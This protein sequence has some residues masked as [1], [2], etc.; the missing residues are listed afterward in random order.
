MNAFENTPVP[1]TDSHAPS[2]LDA[3]IRLQQLQLDTWL[4]WQQGWADAAAEIY[5]EWAC[6]FAGG[7]PIDG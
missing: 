6:R 2:L 4:A 3:A 5:D 7:I 1:G